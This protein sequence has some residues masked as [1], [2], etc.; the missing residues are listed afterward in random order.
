MISREPADA[1]PGPAD[2]GAVAAAQ[3]RVT[4]VLLTALLTALVLAGLRGRIS[5]P[6]P[7]GP[8]R[9][10]GIAVGVILEAVLA[11]LLAALLVRA[12][13][14]P[15]EAVLAARLRTVLRPLLITSLVVIPVALLLVTPLRARPRPLPVPRQPVTTPGLRLPSAGASPHGSAG[16]HIPLSAVLYALLVIALIAGT[17]LCAIVAR[18]RRR[19]VVYPEAEPDADAQRA[20]L[21]DAVESGTSALRSFDDAQAGIIACY[22]SMEESLARA[23]TVRDAADTPD[24]LLAKAADGGLVRGAAAAR[25]TRLFYEARFSSHRL[26]EEQRAAARE[27][28]RDLAEDLAHP[29]AGQQPPATQ[30]PATQP[31]AGWPPGGPGAS[32]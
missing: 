28:L 27:A 16:I 22:L 25:L 18:R 5:L 31:P 1:R 9:G 7:A 19:T 8:Y 20:G 11:V 32:P 21:R 14:A 29:S 26:G 23:G 10:D 30:P 13:R 2:P 6:G 12:R 4:R 15:P 3:A 24:E 17:A